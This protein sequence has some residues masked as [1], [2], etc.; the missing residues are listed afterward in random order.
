M[1][2][3]IVSNWGNYPKINAKIVTF[4]SEEELKE[5][6]T[7]EKETIARGLG[8]C[9]GDSALS[10]TILSTL[11]FNRILY[12]N[13]KDGTITCESGVT[14]EELLEIFIPRGWFLPVT[15][16]TKYITIGGA[17][18]SDIHG[19]NH[20]KEGS[21]SN[22]IITLDLMKD[23]GTVVKCSKE[24]N[25]DLFWATCGGM[26][27]TG[28]IL[29]ATFK[30]TKIETS[31]IKQES[32]KA[33]NLKE[34]MAIF[35]ESK[36]YTYSVAWIDCLAKGKN[37]GRSIMMRGEHATKKDIEETSLTNDPLKVNQKPLL[38][39]PINF[40]DFALNSLSVKAFNFL[41]YNKQLPKEKKGLINYNKFFYPLDGITNWNR[42]YGK[43]GFTQYQFVLPLENSYEALTIILDKISKSGSCSF[44]AVLKPFGKQNDL[45]SFPKEGYT[46]ALDFPITK[47]MFKLLDELDQIVLENNGRLYLTKD[48]RM[49]ESTLKESYENIEKFMQIKELYDRSMKFQ[50][51]QSKRLGL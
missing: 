2:Q 17:I 46:L 35:E 22:H 6:L 40:P 14:L 1:Q 45:I 47:K 39:I 12:F 32:I 27:L 10:E 4:S 51:V 30:L 50:S 20:H 26:G 38:N 44:L 34:I 13:E 3:Q 25:T 8:R 42:I 49:K 7:K 29:R 37:I 5:K 24:E 23:D 18:A 36:D 43:R 33:A 28:V 31:Y 21:I 16:G 11:N 19:K 48:S 15:P 41:Y 9:Y